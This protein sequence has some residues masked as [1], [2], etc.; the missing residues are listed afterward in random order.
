M[1][2]RQGPQ[3]RRA[4]TPPPRLRRP[5]FSSSES[6]AKGGQAAPGQAQPPPRGYAYRSSGM[7]SDDYFLVSSHMTKKLKETNQTRA[8]VAAAA[9]ATAGGAHPAD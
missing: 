1:E 8:G 9:A 5:T 4:S 7:W 3:S 2:Q 6:K